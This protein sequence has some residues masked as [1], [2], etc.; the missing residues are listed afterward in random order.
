MKPK[1]DWMVVRKIERKSPIITPEGSSPVAEMVPFEVLTIGPGKFQNGTFVK[2]TTS[3]G[4]IVFINGPV[5]ETKYN[6]ITYYF[7]REEYVV[8]SI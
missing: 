2:T 7:A 5:S 6:K 3:P 8:S 1:Q 4:D